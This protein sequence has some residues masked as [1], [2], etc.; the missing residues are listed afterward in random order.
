MVLLFL[1]AAS[2]SLVWR[3]LWASGGWLCGRRVLVFMDEP[4]TK[5]GKFARV[6]VGLPAASQPSESQEETVLHNWFFSW[7]DGAPGAWA[8]IEYP[9]R[10]TRCNRRQ[11]VRKE[12]E[13]GV[14]ANLCLQDSFPP[15]KEACGP[16]TDYR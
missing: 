8:E 9:R 11:R 1:L 7:Q 13:H 14:F 6:C 2:T 3:K 16:E 10:K 5:R 15:T 12:H 4:T